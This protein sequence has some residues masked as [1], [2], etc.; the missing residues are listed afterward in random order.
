RGGLRWRSLSAMALLSLLAVSE[1]A[2]RAQGLRP[3]VKP[4]N[5]QIN[6]EDKEEFNKPGSKIW[7]LN[8]A[9]KEPRL[10]TVDIPGRGRRLCWYLTYEVINKTGQPHIFIPDFE[11]VTLDKPGVY[12]DQVLPKVQEAIRQ[13]EDPTGRL[14]IKN[15]VTIA[16]K[17]IPPSP[18]NSA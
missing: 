16:A 5:P 9:F 7:V 11:L 18:P 15:S 14:D 13:I 8:F 6:V 2:A 10:I 17:P 4:A 3:N 12:H 1:G